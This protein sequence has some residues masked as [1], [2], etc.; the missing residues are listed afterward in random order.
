MTETKRQKDGR[1]RRAILDHLK[2]VGPSEAAVL[3]EAHLD[4]VLGDP[5]GRG[6]N[7]P[8]A[9][10]RSAFFQPWTLP[11]QEHQPRT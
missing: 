8:E 10:L 6:A 4:E 9:G 7:A 3:A 1:T 5:C 2:V 11:I